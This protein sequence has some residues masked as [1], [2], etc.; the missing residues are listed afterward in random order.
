MQINFYFSKLL[1]CNKRKKETELVEN[2]TLT[3]SWYVVKQIW[4]SRNAEFVK[5]TTQARLNISEKI[6][7]HKQKELFNHYTRVGGAARFV[8]L[9]EI[10]YDTAA[11]DLP[12]VVGLVGDAQL[13]AD[14]AGIG[15]V[16]GVPRL[17]LGAVQGHGG[18]RDVVA[19]LQKQVGRHRGVHTAAHGGE[20]FLG[21]SASLQYGKFVLWE[22]IEALRVLLG[23]LADTD[24][25]VQ[26]LLASLDLQRLCGGFDTLLHPREIGVFGGVL[27]ADDGCTV[28]PFLLFG[29]AIDMDPH[30][31]FGEQTVKAVFDDG[32]APVL[33][34]LPVEDEGIHVHATVAV[35]GVGRLVALAAVGML[36]PVYTAGGVSCGGEAREQEG[37][38]ALR[39]LSRR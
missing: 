27:Q 2:I 39:L 22:E 21:H 8:D 23:R 12:H 3:Q 14:G 20:Y 17:P 25:C 19:L 6:V 18:S 29:G 7:I 5:N 36:V 28:Y 34:G 30:G 26:N 13:F 32:K 9:D 31:V 38:A 16:L 33:A 15:H 37:G 11:E 1:K 35:V 24:A 4:S 10:I